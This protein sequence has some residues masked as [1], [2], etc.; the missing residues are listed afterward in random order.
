MGW[1]LTAWRNSLTWKVFS[2]CFGAVH[3]PLIGLCVYLALGQSVERIPVLITALVA[4]LF[5]SGLAL[6][7]I[8]RL[9]RPID[10]IVRAVDQ[11]R[12]DRVVTT[13]EVGGTDEIRRLAEGIN[14]LIVE[15]EV[16]LDTYK[17]QA[18]SDPLTGLGNRRWLNEA[19]SVELYR[20]RRIGQCVSVIVFDLDHFKQIND[21][22][23]HA[24]GDQVLMGVAEIARRQL[25]PYD[26]L[27]RIGG[28]EFCIVVSDADLGVA[29]SAAERIR[30]AIAAWKP[31][32]TGSE[33]VSASFGIHHGDPKTETLKAMIAEADAQLYRAKEAGRNAVSVASPC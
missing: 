3:I 9:V 20:A 28:E 2:V 26:L 15:Q 17:R 32:A 31:T 11:Y 29:V 18:N 22:F 5:A 16:A 10:L 4:T 24:T 8:R 30:V 6:L 1:I 13:I 14:A 7:A 12:T 21:T 33:S 27:A 23:G 25:R 19:A